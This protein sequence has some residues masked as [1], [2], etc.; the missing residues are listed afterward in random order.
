MLKDRALLD[1]LLEGFDTPQATALYGIFCQITDQIDELTRRLEL[2]KHQI[3]RL[4]D[5]IQS[6]TQKPISG[7]RL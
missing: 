2:H 1:Q 6:I 7:G 4:N 5:R 3:P